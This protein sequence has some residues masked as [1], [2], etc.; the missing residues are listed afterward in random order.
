MSWQ[1]LESFEWAGQAWPVE[2][3]GGRG[4]IAV[5][6]G[7]EGAAWEKLVV[8][9]RCSYALLY[10]SWIFAGG[11][12]RTVKGNGKGNRNGDETWFN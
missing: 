2:V 12:Q 1:E 3:R 6:A 4:Q 11:E 5:S 9:A 10:G 8:L 7:P